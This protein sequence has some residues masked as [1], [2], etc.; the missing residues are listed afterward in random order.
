MKGSYVFLAAIAFIMYNGIM[1]QGHK[2]RTDAYN[3]VCASL[4]QPHPDC[5][6][7]K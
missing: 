1:I 7:A 3:N 4:S 5:R 2:K 6:Y